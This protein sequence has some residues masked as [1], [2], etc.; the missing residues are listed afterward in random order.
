MICVPYSFTF[1]TPFCVIFNYFNFDCE[2]VLGLHSLN[3]PIC[4]EDTLWLHYLTIKFFLFFHKIMHVEVYCYSLVFFIDFNFV[5]SL[6]NYILFK[7]NKT[8]NSLYFTR[9]ALD[10][11]YKVNIVLRILMAS[12][13]KIMSPFLGLKNRDGSK[14][15]L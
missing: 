4:T 6:I 5:L 15:D 9:K 13:S 2:G 3:M 12:N 1:I 14:W 10:A 7:P 11:M 8:F